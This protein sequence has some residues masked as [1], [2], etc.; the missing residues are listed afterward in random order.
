MTFIPPISWPTKPRPQ[1]VVPATLVVIFVIVSLVI[2]FV[3]G[4]ESTSK[5]LPTGGNITNTNQPLPS[6]LGK[7]VDFSLFWN[8]WER[9]HS[10]YLEQPVVDTKLFYGALEGMVAGLG[11]P[12]SV[13]MDPVTAKK[14]DSELQGNF[15]GIGAEIG[16]KDNILT[17]IAPLS[18]T[19]SAKA[20]LKP[21]DKILAIDKVDTTAMSVDYAVTLIRGA[22]G[23]K[24]N[25]L[26]LSQ[27]E[28][29]SRN[30]EITRSRIEIPLV[31]GELKNLPNSKDKVAYIKLVHFASDTDN[32][33]RSVL[34]QL[35]TQGPKGIIIDLR[36]NPG[37]YLDQ[38]IAISSHWVAKG[39]VVKEQ[40]IPPNFKEHMSIGGGELAGTPTIIL[41]NQG[42]ASA[43]EI[44][45]GALQ[46]LKLATIV[47]E[48][49]FGKGSVQNL[50]E[51][52][53]GSAVKLTVAKWFTP[54][55]RSIDKNGIKPDIEVK[56]SKEDVEKGTD[57]QLDRALELL[58][59]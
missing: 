17:I 40:L 42:S 7:D 12:Y 53:D 47:G 28:N 25:L 32:T 9:I 2:G 59:K 14:F 8:L 10:E 50:E 15:D 16:L 13:F 31:T 52:P 21:G 26:I 24:V 33:F 6:Y 18:G 27:G 20:G 3:A 37:G 55:G 56:F 49:T 35:T 1:R 23:T 43:S 11:D 29:E 58:N 44:V 54:Q 51:L 57:P 19:P 4:Q 46:D 36:N 38:A 39:V 45:A 30:V 48:Q 22:R 34:A 5:Y 41:V